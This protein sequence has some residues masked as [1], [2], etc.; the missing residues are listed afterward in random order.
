MEDIKILELNGT[1]YECESLFEFK[2]SS[3]TKLLYELTKNQK[4]LE[5]KIDL[6]NTRVDEKENRLSNLEIQIKGE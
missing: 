1:S 3:L 6:V 5:K 2:F 4:N